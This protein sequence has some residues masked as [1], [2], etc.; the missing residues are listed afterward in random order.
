MRGTGTLVGE[1]SVLT[2]AHVLYFKELTPTGY[3]YTP[4]Q[5]VSFISGLKGK[6][7]VYG[8][9]ALKFPVHQKYL[10]NDSS[11][12]Y[13]L[14]QIDENIGAK[15]GYASLIVAEDAE[16]DGKIVNVTG[17][18]GYIGA[19]RHLI[20]KATFDMYTAPRPIKFV[21]KNKFNYHIDTSG[22]QSGAGVWVLNEKNIVEC[23]GTHVTGSKLEGNG[24]IRINNH[25]FETI[26]A[27]L[28]DFKDI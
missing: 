14:M 19:F 7:Y 28:K 5:E 16:L 20:G 17:Y 13:C 25:N 4:A 3:K 1:H 9:K 10:Q 23:C 26:E 15:T 27:W 2:A 18:P 6:E 21:D 11:Y 8:A 22:G 24:A 12:D